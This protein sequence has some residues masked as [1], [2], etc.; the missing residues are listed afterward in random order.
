MTK[1]ARHRI[2][3][4]QAFGPDY[5][6]CANGLVLPEDIAEKR[7]ANRLPIGSAC[8]PV[9]GHGPW[10]SASRFSY[11]SSSRMGLLRRP[12]LHSQSLPIW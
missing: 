11:H 9:R 4:A 2:I 7:Y 12:N 5:V 8:S 1:E 3:D 10:I 6:A